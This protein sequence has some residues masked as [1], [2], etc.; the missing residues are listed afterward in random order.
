[1]LPAISFPHAVLAALRQSTRWAGLAIFVGL[2]TLATVSSPASGQDSTTTTEPAAEEE[3]PAESVRGRLLDK[4]GTKDRDD[5]VPVEGVDITVDEAGGEEVGSATSNDEGE[6]EIPVPGPGRYGVTLN[7]DTLPDGVG[8]TEGRNSTELDVRPNQ[9]RIV[10]FALGPRTRNVTTTFDRVLQLGF[11]GIRFGLIIA[12]TS[13]GLSLIFGTTGLTNFAHGEMVTFGAIIAWWF[14]VRGGLNLIV[15]TVLAVVVGFAAAALLDLALWRRLRNRGMSLLAMMVVSIG[16][17]LLL[18]NVYQ[19]TFGESPRPFGDYAEQTGYIVGPVRIAPKE[20]W[21][22]SLSL[23]VLLAVAYVLQRTKIGKAMRAVADNRDLAA[24]SGID[25]DRVILFVWG[26]G[27]ALATLG[28]VLFSLNERVSFNGG[29][30]LLLLMFAGIT[31]GG[32]GTAYGALV[33]SFVVGLFIQLST[34]WVSP[35]LK[36]VGALLV[37][38]LVLLVRPQGILG[39]A[40][41]VG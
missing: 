27:G 25:V 9:A 7:L 13:V 6:F 5:D 19:I 28:G 8:F 36:N 15:A 38:A 18:R 35:E 31:L 3:G 34:I 40:E 30:N 4:K 10:Q 1:M 23:V 37:L 12:I 20:I 17:S 16:L 2:A 24:S 21:A 26:M 39:R 29:F 14:N 11:S 22:I 32:L 33:G 41:R